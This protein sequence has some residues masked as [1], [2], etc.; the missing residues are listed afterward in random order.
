MPIRA[1]LVAVPRGSIELT[2]RCPAPTA[3]G[4]GLAL[5][6]DR[7]FSSAS[8]F[9]LSS[10]RFA[11]ILAEMASPGRVNVD[12]VGGLVDLAGMKPGL[13]VESGPLLARLFSPEAGRAPTDG[14]PAATIFFP[15]AEAEID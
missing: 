10:S 7:F 6:S 15:V 8:F 11:V 13:E 2:L 5:N 3:L 4:A 14:R 12:L 1:L 9:S